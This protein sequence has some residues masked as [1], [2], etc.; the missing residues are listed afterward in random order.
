MSLDIS[1]KF[2][3]NFSKSIKIINLI[4]SYPF[5]YLYC[6]FFFFNDFFLLIHTFTTLIICGLIVIFLK[7]IIKKSRPKSNINNR[8]LGNHFSFPSGHLSSNISL[9]FILHLFHSNFSF[10]FLFTSIT[11]IIYKLLDNDHDF[12]DLVAG[13]LTGFLSSIFSFLL[14]FS[15]YYKII[16]RLSMILNCK[17]NFLTKLFCSLFSL[18]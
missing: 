11:I 1:N 4:L 16:Y 14:L 15:L 6:L 13:I 9:F 12:I 10:F 3:F 18:Y 8:L 5:L 2:K 17:F 7:N